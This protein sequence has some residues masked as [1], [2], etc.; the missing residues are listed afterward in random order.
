MRAVAMSKGRPDSVRVRNGSRF[1]GI[2]EYA[3]ALALLVTG[4]CGGSLYQVKPLA[5]LSPLPATVAFV[6]LGTISIRAAPLLYDEESQELFESNLQLAG[7]LPVRVEIVHNGGEAIEMKKVRFRV[8]DA[9]GAEW[10]AI[11]S[12]QAIAR[13]LKANGV[14]AY[15]PDSR[16]TFEKEFRAYELSLKTPLTH[17]EGRR[18]GFI[19][20]LAPRKEPV[21]SPHG[22]VLTIEGLSEPVTFPLK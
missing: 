9:A 18:E 11:S 6:N 8:R 17:G 22:L 15:N 3:L 2:M 12:K 5:S 21:S 1:A 13:I 4:S 7:L 16:K 20:F 19:I 14:F 10:K